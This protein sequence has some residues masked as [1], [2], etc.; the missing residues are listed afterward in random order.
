MRKLNVPEKY[1]GKKLT[2][3]I[4]DS[5]PHL[6]T[7]M[8]Y[9]ALR[10]KDIKIDGTRTNKDCTIYKGNE[11]LVYISDDLLSPTPELNIVFEDDNILV[12]NKPSCLEV[13]GENSLTSIVHTTYYTSTFLPMPCHRLDRNTTGLILFAKNEAALNILLDKFKKHE[14]CKKYLALVYGIPKIKK[15]KLESYLFKDNKK[16]LVYIS[17]DFK[18]GYQKIITSYSVLEEYN[19]NSTLLEVEIETG[20]THQIRAHLAHIGF[21]IIGDGKYGINSVNKD[22]GFKFQQLKAYQ[23]KFDFKTDS[24]I[25]NYL[26]GK[27]LYELNFLGKNKKDFN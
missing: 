2:K 20:K 8:L 6:S 13:T 27:S 21:P 9:K 22:F 7:N 17:D 4:L 15:A 3:F 18:A 25:L 19:N 11:I 12:I 10:Q 14:I 5:F 1:N 16:S 23:L 24:G 26:N